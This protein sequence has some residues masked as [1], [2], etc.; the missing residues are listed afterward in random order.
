VTP[1]LTVAGALLLGIG[2]WHGDQKPQVSLP[3][4]RQLR[5][6]AIRNLKRSEKDLEKY[7]C[8]VQ[9]QTDELNADGSLKRHK[10]KLSERF[11]LN[12][13]EINHVLERDGKQLEGGAAKKEQ[14]RVDKEVRK[15]SDPVRAQKEK[16][17]DEKQVDLII[18]ALRF[19]NG[20][21]ETREGRSTVVYDMEGD[22]DFHPRKLEERFAQVLSGRIW[23]D[24]ETGMPVEM[25]AETK[26]DVKIGGG[27]LATV[28]KGFNVHFM[29]QRQEENV[30]IVK[31]VEGNLDARAA[32][33]MRPRIRFREDLQKCHIFSVNTEEHIG[34]TPLPANQRP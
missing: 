30:W 17:D 25:R 10:T 28:H 24:E 22:P 13:I 3:D 16:T 9:T 29:Q 27:L 6:R 33:F 2:F 1:L 26:R 18:R 14:E 20:T 8:Q 19:K 21:R 32:L 5:E 15:Y 4:P 7:S 23:M 12:G 11:F 34:T 31:T